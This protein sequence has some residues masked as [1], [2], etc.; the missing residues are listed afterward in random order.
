MLYDFVVILVVVCSSM[1]FASL[2]ST[3]LFESIEAHT[4]VRVDGE[5][6]KTT[7]VIKKTLSPYWNESFEMYLSRISDSC[8]LF[9]TPRDYPTHS[10]LH[11]SKELFKILQSYLSKSSTNESLQNMLTRDFWAWSI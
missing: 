3:P 7:T 8:S 2:H 1:D 4:L 10:K 5:Q 11:L 9:L 6:T